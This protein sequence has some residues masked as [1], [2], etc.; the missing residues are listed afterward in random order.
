VAGSQI[1]T[2]LQ[3]IVARQVDPID[4]AVVSITNF[5]A[6]F[7]ASNVIPD[8]AVLSGTFRAFRVET[9][10]LLKRRIEQISRSIA[11]VMGCTLTINVNDGYDP[12][13]NSPA[14][15]AFCADVARTLVGEANVITEVE[16]CMG[17]EDFGAMLQEVPGC[18]IW[19][20]QGEPDKPGSP[21]N[22]GL[23]NVGYDFNDEVIPLGVEYWS[24]LAEAALPL[25]K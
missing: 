11:E 25:T 2:A 20:G 14:E 7:G 3:T 21:H 19:M 16:P 23:H 9:R 4:H 18:Y 6:G 12:T 17:A 8:K 5:N 15:S 22:K 10:A 24:R 13:I 1:V